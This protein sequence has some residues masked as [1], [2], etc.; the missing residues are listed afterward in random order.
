[1]NVEANMSFGLRING[2]PKA[3]IARRV[4]RASDMLQLGPLLKRKPANLSGGQRQRVAIARAIVKAP[5]MVIADEPTANLDAV[6][7]SQVIDLM[8]RLAHDQGTTF[9][10]ATHDERMIGHCDRALVL[11]DGVLAG[12]AYAH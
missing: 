1:M 11:D 12:G 3:E 8:K 5:Q 6:T 4:S 7:A 10:I 2:T 9:L